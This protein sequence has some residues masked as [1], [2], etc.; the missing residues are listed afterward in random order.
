MPEADMAQLPSEIERSILDYMVSYLK[1]NT[2]Q[3][4]IREIGEEFG[5]KS[6]KT[7]SEHLQALADKGFLERDPARSRGVRI[8]GVDLAPEAVSIPLLSRL[9][10]DGEAGVGTD[11]YLTV[12]RRLAGSEG[13]FFVRAR[14]DEV[15][16]MG[17]RDGDYLLVE[18]VGLHE[19][20]DDGVV[21]A[22][23]GGGQAGYYRIRR[24]ET[25][26][27]LQGLAGGTPM[28]LEDP[29]ALPVMGRVIAFHR[30]MDGA[31]ATP[32]LSTAH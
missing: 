6:T 24:D 12:D 1:R 4:S 20:P 28:H 31:V 19:V 10:D 25:G 2:Y 7:V 3:P 8:L 17:G 13:S 27:R 14:G 32:S 16:L 29:A 23:P 18:P 30:R 15:A 11:D 26:V 5:I 22:R 9:P 21:V